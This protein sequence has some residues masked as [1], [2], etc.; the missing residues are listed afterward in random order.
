MCL[1]TRSLGGHHAG[2]RHE[3]TP[4]ALDTLAK[5]GGNPTVDGGENIAFSLSRQG[6]RVAG[7]VT[8]E[9]IVRRL[10]TQYGASIKERNSHG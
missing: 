4:K 1:D 6:G 8:S 3:Q 10:V 7:G 9:E 2:H 5:C